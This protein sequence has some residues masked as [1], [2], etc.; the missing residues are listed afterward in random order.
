MGKFES[1]ELT[2]GMAKDLT[3]SKTPTGILEFA[4]NAVKDNKEGGLG[5]LHTEGGC[6]EQ[7]QA[8]YT[9]GGDTY[10]P[11]G[12]IMMTPDEKIL[13]LVSPTK[14]IIASITKGVLTVLLT[15]ATTER[16]GFDTKYP[17][18]GAGHVRR[19]TEKVIYWNDAKNP[20]RV[21]NLSQLDNYRN[22]AGTFIPNL[23]LFTPQFDIAQM[24]MVSENDSGGLIALG[25][26]RISLY[27]VGKDNSK[28]EVFY[29][30][31]QIQVA[32]GRA[33][34]ADQAITGGYNKDSANNANSTFAFVS[35]NKSFTFKFTNI[36]TDFNK[37]AI[38]V[39]KYDDSNGATSGTYLVDELVISDSNTLTW[40][41]KGVVAADTVVDYSTITASY[42]R[43]VTCQ[44]MVHIQNRLIKANLVENVYDWA[45]VQRLAQN[46]RVKWV[47]T[48]LQHNK[49]TYKRAKRA[50]DGKSGMR[51]EVASIGVTLQ[52][53][54]G[55]ESPVIHIPGRPTI[56]STTSLVING[57]T[58]GNQTGNNTGS[59][60]NVQPSDN[61]DTKTIT[62]SG[63]KSNN[64]TTVASVAHLNIGLNGTLPRWQMWNT[65]VADTAAN[66]ETGYVGSG[67]MGYHESTNTSYPLV[68]DGD[69]EVVYPHQV[70][71]ANI[72]M[73]KI[74]HHRLPNCELAPIGD[75]IS[76][77][78]PGTYDASLT[79][80]GFYYQLGI[81]IYDFTI[82]PEILPF[83][84]GIKVYW[85][86]RENNRTI[87]E[88][89]YSMGTYLTNAARATGGP[90]PNDQWFV[91]RFP[92]FPASEGGAEHVFPFYTNEQCYGLTYVS[93]KALRG[94]AQLNSE[95]AH[96]E[97]VAHFDSSVHF[98]QVQFD[99]AVAYA[100]HSFNN[101]PRG[102]GTALDGH[103]LNNP[104]VDYATGIYNQSVN[105]DFRGTAQVI[106]NLGFQQASWTLELR[107]GLQSFPYT[108][109]TNPWRG[110]LWRLPGADAIN[111]AGTQQTTMMYTSLKDTRDVYID[112]EGIQYV[113]STDK[114]LDIGTAY[115]SPGTHCFVG[116]MYFFSGWY[117]YEWIPTVHHESYHTGMYRLFLE[118]EDNI[119]L[120][121]E[122]TDERDDF[123][124]HTNDVNYFLRSHHG[125]TNTYHKDDFTLRDMRYHLNPDYSII[126]HPTPRAGIS[127]NIS[128]S[129]EN[130]G[131]FPDR[132]IWSAKSNDEE[133][134]DANLKYAVLDYDD[135]SLDKG[136]IRMLA[137]KPNM[138]YAMTDYSVF[139]KPTNAQGVNMSNSTLFLKSSNFLDIP[140]TELYDT[141]SGYGGCQSRFASINTEY[142][143]LYVN[144]IAGE[145]Y[146][147]N[148]GVKNITAKG[149]GRDL[150]DRLPSQFLYEFKKVT[151]GEY[152]YMDTTTYDD[153][154]VGVRCYF[155][156]IQKRAIISKIDYEMTLPFEVWD[157]VAVQGTTKIWWNN[158]TKRLM[159]NGANV[160]PR[161]DD[162]RFRKRNLTISY[163]FQEEKWL[164][165]HS[166]IPK[167]G[168]NDTDNLYT[169]PVN[170]PKTFKH[171]EHNYL[172]YYDNVRHP[173]IL[174]YVVPNFQRGN[175]TQVNWL[176][177][178]GIWSESHNTYLGNQDKTF[179]KAVVYN[180][181][182]TSGLLDLVNLQ[183]NPFG[184]TGLT[185]NQKAITRYN[186]LWRLNNIWDVRH[187]STTTQPA[188]TEDWNNATYKGF[189]TSGTTQG[190]IDK[191]PNDL[192]YDLNK[193]KFG[194]PL[195][196]NSQ[197]YVRLIYDDQTDNDKLTVDLLSL[198]KQ[199]DLI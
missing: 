89:G 68:R 132:V 79:G 123:F 155:D 180:D 117:R 21:L 80:N 11:V 172:K 106:R 199:Q 18:Q 85:G 36:D 193:S 13:F 94:I 90:T 107:D 133:I 53:T 5:S 2:K 35:V 39:T 20:D 116:S 26:Y 81:R 71:G 165:Y 97:A 139:G 84:K 164:S 113:P 44:Y 143:T 191:V 95:Y 52:M 179:T 33:T 27:Y 47:V 60:G 156:P 23:T 171:V 28:S 87:R 22:T 66:V 135:L 154:G 109:G 43:Y 120:R 34:D 77:S 45:K 186:N 75:L 129:N 93:N 37:L 70:V 14:E 17:I 104:I 103:H 82:P 69:G 78:Y 96:Q 170:T 83:V 144:Q 136:E 108:G 102:F 63:T 54:D 48:P 188:M 173:F 61:W 187:V 86:D 149:L 157:G 131:R 126:K 98:N 194:T 182:G 1:N 25:T 181:I 146:I 161:T 189:F 59:R 10:S 121:G 183:A 111:Y 101:T 151:G 67:I 91:P 4:M 88:K 153:E 119:D 8:S 50:Y 112:L 127:H 62:A 57:V 7:T 185:N 65:A 168:F 114:V 140:E 9:I 169:I 56:G 99:L 73:D 31:N 6:E 24:E 145:V 15:L 192:S 46:A 115:D 177:Q 167:I 32:R 163:D 64:T 40:D 51:D 142:G 176:T 162:V 16:F 19:G 197:T 110:R 3:A 41:F 42:A 38:V 152:P 195:I 138:L 184:W 137:Q 125:E 196:D 74:R 174:E 130:R 55:Q 160:S 141:G 166:W 175:A 12:Y 122:G 100:R 134:E 124:P 49:D 128:W 30:S 158:T 76:R 29:V 147:L 159:Y 118:S 58:Y 105:K 92:A 178:S 148:K 198:F 150:K 72:V 190:F